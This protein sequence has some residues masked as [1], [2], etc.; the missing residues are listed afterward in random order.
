MI[1]DSTVTSALML[2]L[3]SWGLDSTV[4]VAN[5][6]WDP[7]DTFTLPVVV[8]TL[9]N[10]LEIPRLEPA[11][12]DPLARLP[13]VFSLHLTPPPPVGQTPREILEAFGKF[14]SRSKR[15][16]AQLRKT[17]APVLDSLVA[18]LPYLVLDEEDSLVRTR[19]GELN[20]M[21]L[22]RPWSRDTL[23]D[24]TIFRLYRRVPF[25]TLWAQG[26]SEVFALE[27]LAKTLAPFAS[28]LPP[29]EI[30]IEGCRIWV[31][32]WG[33]DTYVLPWDYDVI[34]DPAGS[35]RYQ[36][37]PS[38]AGRV[39][40]VVDF[41]GDDLYEGIGWGEPAGGVLGSAWILDLEGNDIYRGG[42]LSLGAGF[43][44]VGGIVDAG[45]DDVYRCGQF[46]V[47]SAAWGFALVWDREGNDVYSVDEGGEAFARTGGLALL[48]DEKGNDV[49]LA[50]RT[51]PHSPL[52]PDALRGFAQGFAFGYR[53]YASGGLA[54][55]LDREGHDR[56]TSPVY[57][58]GAAYWKG[59]GVLVDEAGSDVYEAFQYAQ[60]AGIHLGVGVLLD[61]EG[62]DR[63]AS[64]FGPAQ[65]EGHD[66]SVGVLVDGRGDDLYEVSGGLGL[67]L[68]NGVGILVD[69][70]GNDFYR[71]SEPRGLGDGDTA[72][73]TGSL[74]L[75]ADL[76][77]NDTYL[78]PHP[79]WANG[80]L[81]TRG[82]W[83]FGMDATLLPDTQPAV[84]P[85][86]QGLGVFLD[87]AS[88]PSLY[89][90]ARKWDVGEARIRVQ[91]AREALAG[92]GGEALRFLI[93][94]KLRDPYPLN[95]RVLKVVVEKNPDSARV[96]LRKALKHPS[97]T[98]V[99]MAVRLLAEIRDTA[100]VDSLFPLWRSSRSLFFKRAFLQALARFQR[101]E[102]CPFL[103]ERLR[104]SLEVIRAYAAYAW[105]ASRCEIS[106]LLDLL[107]D[108]LPVAQAAFLALK[109][110]SIPEDT[111]L[112][113]LEDCKGRACVFLVRLADRDLSW[114]A[115]KRLSELPP[116]LLRLLPP[117]VRQRLSLPPA[118]LPDRHPP[119]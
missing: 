67:G 59:M 4:L 60:G 115:R 21:L 9:K 71:L 86:T 64:R 44:G 105:G 97:D 23:P 6:W 111:L 10:P 118:V 45:G 41:S 100:L 54:L 87:T 78:G 47:G 30:T 92:R 95:W 53:P 13:G 25:K 8:Q 2:L 24:S 43:L 96:L 37:I 32:T 102:A 77:G 103:T 119:R 3:S 20:E 27:S 70:E 91:K 93:P 50:G 88:L 26:F 49:Y 62:R 1:W 19:W 101:P 11:F 75:F 33:Q 76:S 106:P 39:Q 48:V 81:W 7:P 52:L 63:Y 83:G 65:G 82:E 69:R 29:G 22:G 116:N 55:L 12:H 51:R 113:R 58:Q 110:A 57:G 104:D 38:G 108:V 17:L 16:Y 112:S 90:E 84:P 114:K 66:L 36:G 79:L 14:C 73:G 68:A 109:E 72:R 56:Y 74:G 99:G 40:I 98:V 15:F 5:R 61:G 117:E 94:D 80:S 46:C 85:D 42:N 34:L 89:A 31:G 107:G 35:D 18:A 28:R